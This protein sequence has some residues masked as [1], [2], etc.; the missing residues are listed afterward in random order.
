MYIHTQTYILY[1]L[2]D[3]LIKYIYSKSMNIVKF[4]LK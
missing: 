2:Y 4:W 1:N 3:V